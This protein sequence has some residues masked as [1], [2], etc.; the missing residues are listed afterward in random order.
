[1][2]FWHDQYFMEGMLGLFSEMDKDNDSFVSE[3]ELKNLLND[4]L[5]KES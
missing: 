5:G 2:N 1:M 3:Q 4:H